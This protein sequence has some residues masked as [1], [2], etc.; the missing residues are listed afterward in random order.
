MKLDKVDVK[1]SKYIR[2]RD[3]CCMAYGC[4]KIGYSNADGEMIKGLEC[5][6]FHRRGK[7]SV[8]Y[9]PRN[10]NCFC[11]WHHVHYGDNPDEYE[12]FKIRQLGIKVFKELKL[13]S[14][15]LVKKNRAKSYLE[16]KKLY[17]DLKLAL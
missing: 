8:R 15:T 3:G 14:E 13:K 9:D 7:E 5:A 16:V 2:L 11:H 4:P 10:A 6:H 17:D 12:L 1:F